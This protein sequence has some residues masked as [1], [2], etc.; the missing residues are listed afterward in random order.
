MFAGVSPRRCSSWGPTRSPTRTTA[1]AWTCGSTTPATRWPSCG[2]CAT[3]S[4]PTTSVTTRPSRC[5]PPRGRGTSTPPWP[6]PAGATGPR[7]AP[8][9]RRSVPGPAGRRG[10]PRWPATPGWPASSDYWADGSS[11]QQRAGDDHP[12]HLVGALVDLGD[13]G[14]AHHALD[15]EVLGVTGA[16]EELDGVGGHLHGDVG[17]ERLGRGAHPRDVRTA[18]LARGRGDVDQVA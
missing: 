9:S 7:P 12:L 13:L 6:P 16:A 18:L 5:S 10:W 14:I 8:R 2:C 17:G 1:C 11:A 15:R 3:C 4:A